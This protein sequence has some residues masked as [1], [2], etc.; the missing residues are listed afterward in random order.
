MKSIILFDGDCHICN[1]SVQ[2]IIKR[3]TK[4]H[5]L[6][7]S[8]Q[9]ETGIQLLEKHNVPKDINSLILIEGSNY[10]DQST[11]A[12]RISKHLKGLWKLVY[13]L[14]IIPKPIRDFFYRLI[15]KNRYQWFGTIDRCMLPTEEEKRRFL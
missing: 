6:F 2:F 15:A 5:F 1:K 9:S 10:Y 11:A 3:D 14:L 8:L 4:G 7:G 12:L 13:C